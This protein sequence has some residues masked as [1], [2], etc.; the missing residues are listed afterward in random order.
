[1]NSW[2]PVKTP[3]QASFFVVC[4]HVGARRAVRQLIGVSA[5]KE[6]KWKEELREN[7]KNNYGKDLSDQEAVDCA[8][9]LTEFCYLLL[10]IHQRNQKNE[11]NEQ[12]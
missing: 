12:D 5:V 9:R 10:K 3:K 4:R 1:M 11:N 7:L 8:W 2:N 6:Q